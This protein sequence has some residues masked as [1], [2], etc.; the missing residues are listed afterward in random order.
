MSS[1]FTPAFFTFLRSLKRHNDR[2]WFAA[3]RDRYVADVETPM[4]RFITDAGER[5][6]S[7]SR[8][9]VADPRRSGGS[10]HRIYRD[11]RFSHDKS[12]FKTCVA[13][14]FRHRSA[15]KEQAAP[16]FYLHLGPGERF[17]GGGIYHP[18]MPTL[19]RIRQHI[20]SA[21]RTWAAV[22][23]SGIEIEG[24]TLTRAP[25]GFDPAHRFVADLKR[26]DFYAGEEFTERQVT[27]PDFLDRF[28]ESCRDVAPLMKFLTEALGLPWSSSTRD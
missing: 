23:K 27:S 22:L 3:H 6:L 21:P 19:T 12:P 18:E 16:G 10:M 24:D 8:A 11:T 14:H 7:I 13:V 25:A 1:H 20:V 4:L 2:E 26:K 9:F 15:G 28:V 5:L 17:A